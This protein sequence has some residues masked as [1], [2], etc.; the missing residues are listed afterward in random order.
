MR[1]GCTGY[2]GTLK[3]EWLRIAPTGKK[4]AFE[5]VDIFRV[6]NGKLAEHWDMM[7]I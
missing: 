7:D 5:A 2:A 1:S 3:K 6:K 4:Y